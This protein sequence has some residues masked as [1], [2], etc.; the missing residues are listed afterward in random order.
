MGTD[1]HDD[2]LGGLQCIKELEVDMELVS[3]REKNLEKLHHF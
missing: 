3:L 1:V 2:C